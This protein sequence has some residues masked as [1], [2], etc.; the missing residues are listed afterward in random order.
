M[1][2]KDKNTEKN[3][4]IET[5]HIEVDGVDYSSEGNKTVLE[6]LKEINKDVPNLCYLEGVHE[7]GACRICLVEDLDTGEL[8]TACNT[9]LEAEMRLE[10]KNERVRQ[11]RIMNLEFLLSNHETDCPSCIKNDDCELRQITEEMGIRDVRF[12]GEK[13]NF[14]EDKSTPALTRVPDKCINCRRCENICSDTQ[15][16]NALAAEGRGFATQIGPAFFDELANSPCVMC[17]QCAVACP[18][19]AITENE[20]IDDVWR[21]LNDPEQHVVVQTAPAVRVAIAEEFSL[22]PGTIATGKMVSALRKMGF[23]GVFD[24]QFAADLTIMEEGTEFIERFK[25]GEEIPLFTSCS[26][27]WIKFIE[28]FYPGYL[29]NLSSCKSPQQMFGALANSYYLEEKDLNSEELT[30]VS[31]MPCTAKKYEAARPEMEDDVDFVLTTREM[32]Q[33]IKQ[34]GMDISN[35]EEDDFDRLLGSSTGAA[36]IFGT[37]GGVM[38]AALRTAYELMTGEELPGVDFAPARGLAEGIKEATV[39]IE[40]TEVNI[41]IS[42][43]LKNARELLE[44]IKNGREYH[45]VEFMSCPGGCIGGGGQPISRDRDTLEKRMEA[46]YEIDKNKERRKSHENPQVEELY[47]RYLE[48]PGSSL[49]HELLHTDYKARD[50]F[51]KKD[52]L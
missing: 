1:T 33:M 20:S 27:G 46:L 2:T 22:P 4:Q 36:A 47:Q 25:N 24:T 19:G 11:T 45:F 26:P 12:P 30:V 15:S 40:G 44:A 5:L 43:G 14:P 39:E 50:A 32:A 31:I 34:L 8:I 41:A 18:T 16:V 21:A 6:F 23:D 49:A 38:E 10:T 42:H 3:E 13:T 29:A 52:Q 7:S 17:G 9:P 28:A 35:L 37:T 48:E 51:A